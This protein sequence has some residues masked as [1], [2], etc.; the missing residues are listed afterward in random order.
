MEPFFSSFLA[1]FFWG[2]AAFAVFV[3]ILLRLGVKHVLAA[4]DARDAKI[5][6]DLGDAEAANRK[7]QE[8]KTG[9]ERTIRETED[10]VGALLAQARREAD[11]ARDQVLKKGAAE[12]EQLRLRAQ[13]DIEAARHAAIVSIRR[14]VADIAATVAAKIVSEKLDQDR[15][16]QLVGEAIDAYERTRA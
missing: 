6:K 12:V 11:E 8:L 2:L 1:N 5:A 15:Q 3:L 10:K 7:A 4:I 16:S 13:Q 14:E 9:L